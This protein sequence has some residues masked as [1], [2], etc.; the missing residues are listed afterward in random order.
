M[1]KKEIQKSTTSLCK[2]CNT[3][4]LYIP[5]RTLCVECY[6]K[7]TKWTKPIELVHFISDD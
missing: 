2:D 4:F 5:S 1:S 3:S 7:K 6:K